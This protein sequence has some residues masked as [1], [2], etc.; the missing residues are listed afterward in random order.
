MAH[1]PSGSRGVSEE[2]G[3]VQ[4]IPSRVGIKIPV[5]WVNHENDRYG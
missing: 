4:G 1:H 2:L 5:A 3:T